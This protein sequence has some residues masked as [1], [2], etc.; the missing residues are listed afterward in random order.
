[1]S[2]RHLAALGAIAWALSLPLGPCLQPEGSSL[3]SL[4]AQLPPGHS[5]L[6]YGP[7]RG[8]AGTEPF[9]SSEPARSPALRSVHL[10]ASLL[11]VMLGSWPFQVP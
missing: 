3:G 1:M 4:C 9:S 10:W 6:H 5:G 2:P 7:P 11:C 8:G